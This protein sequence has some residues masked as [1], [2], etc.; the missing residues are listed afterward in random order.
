MANGKELKESKVIGPKF[1]RK[2]PRKETTVKKK[3]EQQ[4]TDSTVCV[5]F[6]RPIGLKFP[7]PDGR[8]VEIKGNGDSMVGKGQ[9]GLPI[10]AYGFTSINAEDWDYIVKKFGGMKI[11]TSGLCYATKRRSD[12]KEEAESRDD[13][14]NGLEP[15]DVTKTDSKEDTGE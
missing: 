5:A 1:E 4:E 10:G 7:M 9:K 3:Q 8:I 14:R 2:A 15:V 12:A 11:F 6:N 13:L